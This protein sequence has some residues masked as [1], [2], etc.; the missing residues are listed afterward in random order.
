MSVLDIQQPSC[1]SL[2]NSHAHETMMEIL[3]MNS[4]ESMSFKKTKKNVFYSC[5]KWSTKEL[6]MTL[7]SNK[8]SNQTSFQLW[9]DTASLV[10]F[11]FFLFN[12][13]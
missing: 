7:L 10:L 12:Q 1:A 3:Y 13:A 9:E 6:E 5:R 8:C 11:M 2:C 4:K